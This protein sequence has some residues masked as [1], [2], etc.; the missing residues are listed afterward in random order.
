MGRKAGYKYL[1]KINK[2]L[3]ISI[4]SRPTHRIVDKRAGS[5]HPQLNK[6]HISMKWQ[7]TTYQKLLTISKPATA[8]FARQHKGKGFARHQKIFCQI[9]RGTGTGVSLSCRGPYP[10]DVD[11]V[12]HSQPCSSPIPTWG[13]LQRTGCLQQISPQLAASQAPPPCHKLQA[14]AAKKWPSYH[15]LSGGPTGGGG[16]RMGHLC[17]SN[18]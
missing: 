8:V 15:T 17:N 5:L 18:S 10:P 6:F 11:R 14:L 13:F 9:S 4:L 16:G 12:G 7:D 2:L 1:K 3:I